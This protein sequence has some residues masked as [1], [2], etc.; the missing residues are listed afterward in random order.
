MNPGESDTKI[1]FVDSNKGS[2]SGNV[3]SAD[4]NVLP[5]V[6]LTLLDSSSVV[7]R[8][9]ISD[10]N[11]NY[12]FAKVPPGN[13]QVVETNPEDY[14]SNVSDKDNSPDGDSGDNNDAV[15]N[16]ITVTVTPGEDDGGNDFVDDNDGAI[17]GSVAGLQAPDGTF[18]DSVLTNAL[19]Q[20]TFNGVEPGD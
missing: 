4:G 11:G 15:D 19:G 14:P 8:T 3:S 10:T 13:Y 7:L 1:N 2:I 17:S 12:L 6:L 20:Y 9:T 18:V 5:N 16:V